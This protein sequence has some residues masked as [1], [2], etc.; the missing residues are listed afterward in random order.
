[1]QL[2]LA[3]RMSTQPGIGKK[4]G[5]RKSRRNDIIIYPVGIARFYLPRKP[6]RTSTIRAPGTPENTMAGRTR[7]GLARHGLANGTNA[8]HVAALERSFK[9]IP[10]LIEYFT[11]VEDRDLMVHSHG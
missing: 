1:M 2:S 3:F 10:D 11:S 4:Y 6:I 5:F 7:R 9:Q 8:L